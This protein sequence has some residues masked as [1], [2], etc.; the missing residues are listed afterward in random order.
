VVQV[1]SRTPAGRAETVA[2]AGRVFTGRQVREALGLR[3]NWF[4]VEV[5][6]GDV[7]FLVRGSGH[8]VGMAQYGADGMARAG[9][10]Y[11]DILA[12]YYRGAALEKRY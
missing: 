10:G 3:S 8:G 4:D 12:Y 5:D 9:F 6:G 7:V 2:V 11:A 1:L